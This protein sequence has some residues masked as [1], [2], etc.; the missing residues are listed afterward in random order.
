M[1]K[2][3]VLILFRFKAVDIDEK[4]P[5][6]TNSSALKMVSEGSR[7]YPCLMPMKLEKDNWKPVGDSWGLLNARTGKRLDPTSL[8]TDQDIECQIGKYMT[9]AFRLW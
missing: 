4:L 3:Y 1:P 7:G 2:K 6:P 5:I 8:V 9:L